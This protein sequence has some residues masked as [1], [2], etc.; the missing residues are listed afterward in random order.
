MQQIIPEEDN[1][2]DIGEL[3][4]NNDVVETLPEDIPQEDEDNNGQ[5]HNNDAELD[6]ASLQTLYNSIL[7]LQMLQQE[8]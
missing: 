7:Y 5:M 4:G 1:N 8:S 6:R 2:I 3:D